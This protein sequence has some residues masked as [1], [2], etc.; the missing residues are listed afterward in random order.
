MLVLD[1]LQHEHELEIALSSQAQPSCS[2]IHLSPVR[3]AIECIRE[4]AESLMLPVDAVVNKLSNVLGQNPLPEIWRNAI[5]K[6]ITEPDEDTAAGLSRF[7]EVVPLL[8]NLDDAPK[9]SILTSMSFNPRVLSAFAPPNVV[10]SVYLEAHLGKAPQSTDIVEFL[11]GHPA[12]LK[13]GSLGKGQ[14]RRQVWMEPISSLEVAQSLTSV[15]PEIKPNNWIRVTKGPYIDD[16]GLVIRRETGPAQKRLAVLLVPHLPPLL[17]PPIPLEHSTH[18]NHPIASDN[19]PPKPMALA[20]EDAQF[21]TRKRKRAGEQFAQALF[22][23]SRTPKPCKRLGAQRYQMGRDEFEH[24]LLIGK[25]SYGSVTREDVAMDDVTRRLLKQSNHPNLR[26]VHLPV[27]SGWRFFVNDR[28]EVIQSAPLTVSNIIHPEAPHTETYLKDAIIHSIEQN[29][30]LVQFLEYAELNAEDTQ[31]WVRSINL[32]KMFMIGD[33]IMVESGE[34]AG[35][36]G[37]VVTSYGDEIVV[38][39]TENG[40]VKTFYVDPNVCRLTTA[41]QLSVVPWINRHV[42]ISTGQ[43]N[44]YTGVVVDVQ[45]PQ[46]DYTMLIVKIPRLME[47]V[48]VR[49]DDVL[50]TCSNRTLQEAYPLDNTQQNFRQASWGLSFAPNLRS[51]PMDVH[52]NQVLRPEEGLS[53]QP[54]Q[55]WIGVEVMVVK[56]PHKH[57][58]TVKSVERNHRIPSGLRVSVELNYMSAE[59]GAVP[60]KYFDYEAVRDP[61]TGLPLHIR[62]PLRGRERYWEPLTRIKAVSVPNP[63]SQKFSLQQSGPS[64]PPWN[65]EDT[66]DLFQ[67]PEAGSSSTSSASVP[68]HW[69]MDHRLDGKEFFACWKPANGHNLAKVVAKPDCTHQRVQLTHGVEKWYVPPQEIHNLALP[70][71]PT[72]NKDPL[73]VV[74]GEHT[75]KYL[76]HVFY[77]YESGE[78]EPLITAAVYLDWGTTGEKVLEVEGEHGKAV[79]V[80]VRAE[81]CARTAY[82]PNKSKFKDQIAALRAKARTS[83][84]GKTP[85]RPYQPKACM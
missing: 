83:E 77:T 8:L 73:I 7:N 17:P 56:G 71:K 82:D 55:P 81:D 85:R 35:Q 57:R 16:I 12:V 69:T 45:P 40:Q 50:D 18:P 34:F 13:T 70:I 28:V 79:E 64:T 78:K 67:S 65:S 75:G 26:L 30:C 25:F 11:C 60:E 52:T 59:H 19:V 48:R 14:T 24:G 62:H 27:S 76:R 74:C 42:T 54:E 4:F 51:V 58:G 9:T 36:V 31:V 37:L 10:G 72:T 38:A 15:R 43:Y 66:V 23:P 39:N 33:A 80:Q 29:C 63:K 6:A 5:D 84:K 20:S 21:H 53:R 44:Q 2:V 32:R 68:S 49:H 22:D 46:P 3:E 1:I 41:R 61:I 47:T